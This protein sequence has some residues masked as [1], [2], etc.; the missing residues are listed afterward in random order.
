MAYRGS[1]FGRFWPETRADFDHY[2][3]KLGTNLVETKAVQK[4][5][6]AH[7]N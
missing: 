2:C 1:C 4:F 7:L 3:L 6:Q 5:I